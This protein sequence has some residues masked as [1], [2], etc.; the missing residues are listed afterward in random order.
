MMQ[1]FVR[2]SL[3]VLLAMPSCGRG[4]AQQLPLPACEWCG[5]ADAPRE[6]GATARIAPPG[7]PGSPLAISGTVRGVARR[8]V[9]GVLVY[10]YHTNARGVYPRRGD[11]TG[12]ARRHGSLRAWVRTDAEG[13]YAFLTIRPAAY[14]GR[15]EPAHV[16][17][18]VMP[19]GGVESWVDAVEFDDD[20]L[21]TPAVRGRRPNTGG[22]G[23]VRPVTDARGV[24]HVVRDI[25][26]ERGS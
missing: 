16:H 12:N 23:I 10:A 2:L 11:E 1:P 15:D 20:P 5:A 24:Q 4:A 8:P 14:P 25:T 26:L 9:P 17:L 3:L 22:P 18:T 13:R 7:E 6:P 19:R 21:L